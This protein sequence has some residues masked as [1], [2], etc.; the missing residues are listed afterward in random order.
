MVDKMFDI[1]KPGM[2]KNAMLV[3]D[4][5]GKGKPATHNLPHEDHCY[6]APNPKQEHGTGSTLSG[7][8]G[9]THVPKKQEVNYMKL[10][11]MAAKKGIT[12]KTAVDFKKSNAEGI[13]LK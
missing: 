1:N 5:I 7:W 3:R 10:N 4:Q 12:A 9:K 13:R 8:I 6:G 11:S 2:A